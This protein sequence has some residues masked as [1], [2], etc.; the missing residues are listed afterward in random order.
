MLQRSRSVC[1]LIILLACVCAS[2]NVAEAGQVAV[3]WGRRLET[4]GYLAIINTPSP[5]ARVGVER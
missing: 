5:A 1:R 4:G 3:L 2:S